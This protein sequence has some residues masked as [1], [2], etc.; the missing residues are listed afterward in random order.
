MQPVDNHL[1]NRMYFRGLQLEVRVFLGERFLVVNT[2]AAADRQGLHRLNDTAKRLFI[3]GVEFLPLQR[4]ENGE[5][6]DTTMSSPMSSVMSLN[7]RKR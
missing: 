1:S 2:L 5:I 3:S 7:A 4:V 6:G